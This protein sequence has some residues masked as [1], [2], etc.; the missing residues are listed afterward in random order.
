MKKWIGQGA[1]H[2]QQIMDEAAEWFVEVREGDLDA[3]GEQRLVN[4][5][6]RSPEH[7]Q[8][9]LQVAALWADVPQLVS[10]ERIDI[11]A[12]ITYAAQDDNVVTL[13][14]SSARTRA[15]ASAESGGDARKGSRWKS[16][17]IAASV[18][19]L[20]VGLL[21]GTWL[22]QSR[23]NAYETA[24]GEQRSVTLADGSTID[25][26]ARSQIRVRFTKRGRNVELIDGQ[27]LFTVAH[28]PSRPFIVTS[29]DT[30]VRAVGTQ[31]VMYR[32]K[33]GTTVTVLE[34]KVS[35]LP[36]A[37]P[38]RESAA[39]PELHVSTVTPIAGRKRI[40]E[41]VYLTAGEQ[42][43]M[44]A[45]LAAPPKVIDPA[46]ATAWT[47]RQIVFEGAPLTEVVEEFNRYNLRQMVIVS[48]DLESVRVSGV[49]SSTQPESLMRFLREQV[50]L[51]VSQDDG[52]VEIARR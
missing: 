31:F 17:A 19:L 44:S 12:L 39:D 26:N 16:L 24:I 35:V 32:R 41:P 20:A 2:N 49:F 47:H 15:P 34:G 48:P 28:D 11:D 46:T 10:K 30:R 27:A 45:R 52:T 37:A 7:I 5:L 4:W 22:W 13:A 51:A 42:V 6:R 23:G 14:E 1:A 25:L 50:G 18:C 21:S 36:A 38:Q 43:L 9:Y 29:D 3:Q 33:T 8:A 40:H